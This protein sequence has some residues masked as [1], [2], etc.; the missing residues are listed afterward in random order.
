MAEG[1]LGNAIRDSHGA[2]G[3][4]FPF[5]SG[6]LCASHI[7][8]VATAVRYEHALAESQKD[9]INRCAAMINRMAGKRGTCASSL[10]N[11]VHTDDGNGHWLLQRECL[12]SGDLLDD[13][14]YGQSYSALYRKDRPA[15][16]SALG[17]LWGTRPTVADETEGALFPPR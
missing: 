11:D 13:V 7:S 2:L 4:N 17:N 14:F 1:F 10:Y 16:L 6:V 5:V 3:R 15:E 8:L 9:D 12:P